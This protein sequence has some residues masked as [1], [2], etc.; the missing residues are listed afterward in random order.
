MWLGSAGVVERAVTQVKIIMDRE[1]ESSTLTPH[2]GSASGQ[3]CGQL[4]LP[5]SEVLNETTPGRCVHVEGDQRN[6]SKW[7]MSTMKATSHA[8]WMPKGNLSKLSATC[9][10]QRV[11]MDLLK[12]ATKWQP[13]LSKHRDRRSPR[14]QEALL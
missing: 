6:S 11:A 2:V 10:Q 5:L 3:T 13:L 14:R 8:N 12:Q 4:V 7:A 1:P 9:R